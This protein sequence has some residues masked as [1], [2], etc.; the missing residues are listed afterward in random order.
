MKSKLQ[1][2]EKLERHVLLDFFL[3]IPLTFTSF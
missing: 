2:Q 3:T 1:N